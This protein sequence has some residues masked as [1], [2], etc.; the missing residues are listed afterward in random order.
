MYCSV[1]LSIYLSVRPSVYPSIHPSFHVSFYR[2]VRPS[3]YLLVCHP[4]IHPQVFLCMSSWIGYR[5]FLQIRPHSCSSGS[6]VWMCDQTSSGPLSDRQ[7]PAALLHKPPRAEQ[8]LQPHG[9]ISRECPDLLLGLALQP[10]FVYHRILGRCSGMHYSRTGRSR[11]SKPL[12]KCLSARPSF[13]WQT[14]DHL[15]SLEYDGL[16]TVNMFYNYFRYMEG[17]MDGWIDRWTDR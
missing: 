15:K 6:N 17:W 2:S 11:L 1:V 7:R 5:I 9:N 12:L 4:S 3:I 10:A 14:T 16:S 8:L 13:S